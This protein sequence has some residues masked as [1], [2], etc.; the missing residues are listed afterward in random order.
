VVVFNPEQAPEA[1]V[2]GELT[3]YTDRDVP[4]HRIRVATQYV[5]SGME[6]GGVAREALGVERGR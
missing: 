4:L 3:V 5:P 1:A 6:R 2:I